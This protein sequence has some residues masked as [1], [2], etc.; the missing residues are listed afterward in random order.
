ML[1]NVLLLQETVLPNNGI[2]G[3]LTPQQYDRTALESRNRPRETMPPGPTPDKR[4]PA[5]IKT[6]A[7]NTSSGAAC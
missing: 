4:G 1:L 6:E 5:W 3:A 7:K 2:N